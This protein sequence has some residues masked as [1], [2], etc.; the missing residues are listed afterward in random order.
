MLRDQSLTIL[1][2][3]HE[4]NRQLA[5]ALASVLALPAREIGMTNIGYRVGPLAIISEQANRDL[6]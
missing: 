2:V 3:L 1:P 4:R 5:A 6:C